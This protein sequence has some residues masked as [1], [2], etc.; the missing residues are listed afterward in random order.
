MAALGD[1][2]LDAITIALQEKAIDCLDQGT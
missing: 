1:N 2:P